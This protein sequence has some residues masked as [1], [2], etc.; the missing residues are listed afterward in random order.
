[1]AKTFQ[2]KNEY[3][4]AEPMFSRLRQSFRGHR[5]SAKENLEINAMLVDL[6]RLQNNVV[7]IEN[8]ISSV[9]SDLVSKLNNLTEQEILE[10]G[11]DFEIEDVEVSFQ[12]NPE[13]NMILETL[14]KISAKIQRTKNKIERLELN[15]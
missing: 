3:K 11:I 8:K 7:L 15:T 13:Q 12:E 6:H 1:M 5:D 10:D 14:N 4:V 9:Q 2:E